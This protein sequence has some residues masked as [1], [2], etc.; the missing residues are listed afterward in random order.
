MEYTIRLEGRSGGNIIARLMQ[1]VGGKKEAVAVSYERVGI[2]AW[3]AADVEMV[4]EDPHPGRYVLRVTV[5]DLV[6]GQTVA[7]EAVFTV[8]E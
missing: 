6:I 7:K 5:T 2:R 1:G 8:A 4:L 3:E